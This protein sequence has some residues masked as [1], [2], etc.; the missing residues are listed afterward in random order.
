MM[1]PMFD[2]CEPMQHKAM[3]EIFRKGQCNDTTG[4]KHSVKTHS[5]LRNCQ[6]ND[7]EQKRYQHFAEI[8][9]GGHKRS[10]MLD[11]LRRNALLNAAGEKVPRC[12]T[13]AGL[14]SA[15]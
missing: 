15:A 9:D 11:R 6:Q 8:D 7:C 12:G 10:L 2:W 5:E 3:H 14:G 1:Q 13:S 4:E